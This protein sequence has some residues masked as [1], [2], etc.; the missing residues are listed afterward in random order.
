MPGATRGNI[1]YCSIH[2]WD[3]QKRL[4]VSEG[5]PIERLEHPQTIQYGD[6]SSSS[7]AHPSYIPRGVPHIS[8]VIHFT[9]LPSMIK[10][11]V[12]TSSHDVKIN[13]KSQARSRLPSPTHSLLPCST[14]SRPTPPAGQRTTEASGRI[15]PYPGPHLS[16]FNLPLETANMTRAVQT[17]SLG[18][19]LSSVRLSPP[20]GMLCRGR[21]GASIPVELLRL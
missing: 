10:T 8:L 3:I 15:H 21:R 19:L 13:V 16:P 4:E 7:H 20:K 1:Q 12:A 17:L 9:R 11:R 2:R 18:L 6:V 5:S 14:R